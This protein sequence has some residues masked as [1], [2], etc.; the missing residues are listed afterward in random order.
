MV[1]GLPGFTACCQATERNSFRMGLGHMHDEGILHHERHK[2]LTLN[3]S[4]EL[5]ITDNFRTGIVFNG[6][7]AELPVERGVFGAIIAAPIAPVFNEEYGLYHIMPDFQ[8][9]SVGNPMVDIIAH[10]PDRI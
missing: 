7:R 8:R 9:T 3:I 10:G 2:Q 5:K 1:N 4:D 6:Y